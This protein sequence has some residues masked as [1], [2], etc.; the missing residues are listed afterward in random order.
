M[1]IAQDNI[2]A[3]EKFVEEVATRYNLLAASPGLGRRRDELGSGLRSFP[4]QTYLIFYREIPD[5]VQI[6][7]FL[8]GYR[9]IEAFFE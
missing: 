4:Y 3:A 5:G 7:R 6:I 2:S 1:F 8:S 9:D